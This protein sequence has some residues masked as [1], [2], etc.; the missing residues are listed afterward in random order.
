MEHELM[1]ERTRAGLA[2]AKNL[3]CRWLP[4]PNAAS[5]RFF[6]FR[7]RT[8]DR[9]ARLLYECPVKF[10]SEKYWRFFPSN[11]YRFESNLFITREASLVKAL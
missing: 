10:R 5:V 7:E 3:L 1:I 8:P 4:L 9:L 6:P 11:A 2:A